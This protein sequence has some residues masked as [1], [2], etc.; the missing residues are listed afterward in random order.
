M[1]LSDDDY[2]Q[3]QDA[4]ETDVWGRP[5][6]IANSLQI[7]S[8][9]V[10]YTDEVLKFDKDLYKN[11]FEN[12]FE[13]GLT[14]SKMPP[15]VRSKLKE[16]YKIATSDDIV[17][18]NY[19]PYEAKMYLLELELR[20]ERE[21]TRLRGIDMLAVV[22]GAWDSEADQICL[23]AKT[24]INRSIGGFERISQITQRTY[25]KSDNLNEDKISNGEKDKQS[26]WG[27]I[28]NGRN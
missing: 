7:Q 3:L 6:Q 11:S 18:G 2:R 8:N 25:S 4:L 23:A 13:R 1:S 15:S 24:R 5:V 10:D 20:L 16:F 9:E 12:E 14:N 17:L 28:R 27:K 19:T 26:L 21:K 22:T